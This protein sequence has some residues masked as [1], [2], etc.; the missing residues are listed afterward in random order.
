MMTVRLPISP[1]ALAELHACPDEA[2]LTTAEAAAF[3]NVS[4]STL[5]WYR[6]RSMGPSYVKVGP[7][8]VRYMASVLRSY[9]ASTDASGGRLEA[10]G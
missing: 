4:P 5:N 6:C 1:A 10:G 8:T 7:K 9:S 2:L 3:L